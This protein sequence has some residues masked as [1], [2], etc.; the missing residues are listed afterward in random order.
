MP[1]AD[2][3]SDAQAR[4]QLATLLADDPAHQIEARSLLD[5]VVVDQPLNLEARSLLSDL[6]LRVGRA[7]EAA[8]HL[9][10]AFA[11][12]DRQPAR[13]PQLAELL[14]RAGRLPEALVILREATT[15]ANP[16]P[17]L[18]VRQAEVALWTGQLA[19]ARAALDRLAATPG[20][21]AWQ[22]ADLEGQVA[23]YSGDLAKAETAWT[24]ALALLNDPTL[25]LAKERRSSESRRLRRQLALV[26]SWRNQT[27]RAVPALE[28]A[29]LDDPG[30]A[31]VR[32][33]LGRQYLRAAD[34]ASAE[35]TVK[36]LTAGPSPSSTDLALWGD[37]CLAQG[38]FVDFREA[39]ER[40]LQSQ[41][42]GSAT[43][44]LERR[45]A[46]ALTAAGDHARAWPIYRRLAAAAP[47]D[48]D[49]GLALAWSL[50]SA[51]RY[52]QA[53]QVCALLR[54]RHPATPRLAWLE[55]RI[56]LLEKDFAGALALG[57]TAAAAAPAGSPEA[58]AA[59]LLQAE[60][61]LGSGHPAS[62]AVA[63][64]P[65]PLD[66]RLDDPHPIETLVDLHRLLDLTGQA[67]AARQLLDALEPQRPLHPYLR[68]ARLLAHFGERTPELE[69]AI[70]RDHQTAPRHLADWGQELMR[71][72]RLSAAEAAFRRALERQP[73]CLPARLGLVMLLAATERRREALHT[74]VP[75]AAHPS[76]ISWSVCGRP[77]CWPG[78]A[79]TTKPARPTAGC[80][81][82]IPTIPWPSA[83]APAWPSGTNAPTKLEPCTAA[84]HA[85]RPIS[86]SVN[87]CSS[88][89]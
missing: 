4:L 10:H 18:L 17:D 42:N 82:P 43:L 62:A 8:P 33:E 29:L 75:P 84:T 14:I 61:W 40:A 50:A 35:A 53:R 69:Q 15:E 3:I 85:R 59:H 38:R 22:V 39:Y 12:R 68:L 88:T 78:T 72:Q 52:A 23:L 70:A 27:G 7:A 46:D 63:L 74:L 30:D 24:K 89:V 41:T 49:L 28:A 86:R 47:A 16:P 76:I 9:D 73:D 57:A 54:L 32:R 58:F 48:L 87:G 21:L 56:R 45:W 44:A 36:P 83:K 25:A 1:P 13:R 2:W 65:L 26:S 55:G 71:R 5:R 67:T 31:E 64:A 79:A 66:G 37:V 6:L 51:E 11:H 19:E 81:R 77:A 20:A 80:G 60:A 34:P